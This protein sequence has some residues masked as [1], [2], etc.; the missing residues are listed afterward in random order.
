MFSVNL[1][2]CISNTVRFFFVVV[3][4]DFVV[5]CLSSSLGKESNFYL[6]KPFLFPLSLLFLGREPHRDGTCWP[7]V[8]F[9]NALVCAFIFIFHFLAFDQ[10]E[11]FLH[12][13]LKHKVV[14][15]YSTEYSL[16]KAFYIIFEYYNV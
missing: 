1:L 2:S 11:I 10:F 5:R 15:V 6:L 16:L 4:I 7:N 8:L 3:E 12:K 9:S 13:F 14:F